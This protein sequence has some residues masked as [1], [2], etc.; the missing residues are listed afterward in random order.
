MGSVNHIL[1]PTTDGSPERNV[2]QLK[3]KQT[4]TS[5]ILWVILAVVLSSCHSSGTWEDDPKNWDRAF[6]SDK[7]GDVIVLHSRYWR[8]PHFTFE[9]EYFF[10]IKA[11]E[12]LRKQLFTMNGLV[13]LGGAEA[14]KAFQDVFADR[15]PWFLPKTVNKY[16]VWIFHDEP[17]GNFRVFIDRETGDLFLTDYHA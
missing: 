1:S 13:K 11:H 16:D 4:I 3:N 5:Q 12:G 8:S 7:P 9:F 2:K 17:R 10:E 15:P 6:R 14:S